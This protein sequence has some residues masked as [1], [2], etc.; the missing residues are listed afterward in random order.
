VALYSCSISN[1]K[2]S[3]GKSSV[4]KAAYNSRSKLLDER[5][6]NKYDYSQKR[7]LGFSEIITPKN[8][9]AWASD[10]QE[11]WSKNELVNKRRDARVAKEILVALPRELDKE[12][13][14]KLVQDFVS[15]NL[16]P[17]GVVADV[18]AHELEPSNEPDWN[19]HV[20]ILISTNQIFDG[21][22][23]SKITE[24]NKKEFVS[25]LREAWADETNLALEAAGEKVRV[26]HR[27]NEARGIDR[28]PQI[29]LGHKVWAIKSKGI[30]TDRGGRHREIELRNQEVDKI[31]AEVKK[32]IELKKVVTR[33]SHD[34]SGLIHDSPQLIRSFPQL[35]EDWHDITNNQKDSPR[36]SGLDVVRNSMSKQ[37]E[38][39]AKA[40]LEKKKSWWEKA[41][42]FVL[43]SKEE[44]QD[45]SER[46]AKSPNI[47]ESVKD[48]SPNLNHQKK[49]KSRH[50]DVVQTKEQKLTL[51]K[52]LV[53]QI[54]NNREINKHLRTKVGKLAVLVHRNQISVF[55]LTFS[56][57]REQ[58]EKLILQRK[59]TGWEIIKYEL[60]NQHRTRLLEVL[61]T[62]ESGK[63]KSPNEIFSDYLA[64]NPESTRELKSKGFQR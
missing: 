16:T 21:E 20:H 36:I 39:S 38:A 51:A 23:G 62:V 55:S 18:N 3:E 52:S 5:T 25:N 14:L 26:D 10:R 59:E 6:N 4:A 33:Q 31:T 61:K 49:P 27:S 15:N 1:I 46:I 60:S 41:K 64:K 50:S 54:D 56:G 12:Q 17:L 32:A 9:P 34:S 30:A 42:D 35:V 8:A 47:Q 44:N 22:F 58:Q 37:I 2:R 53:E 48:F 7:D 11:L 45:L 19:P 24:L 57:S 43:G 40:E 29:H 63:V 28:I 13:Q